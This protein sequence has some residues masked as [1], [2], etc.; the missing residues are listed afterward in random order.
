MK[1]KFK[2]LLLAIV[3]ITAASCSDYLDT[4]QY[5]AISTDQAITGYNDAVAALVGMYDGLQGASGRTTYYASRMVYYGDVR[6]DDMQA[7]DAGKRTSSCYEMR[8]SADDAPVIWATPYDANRRANNLIKALDEGKVTDATAEEIGDLRSQALVVRALVHFDLVRVYGNPYTADNG[9]SLGVPIV[10]E[11]LAPSAT[12]G[13][14]TVAEVYDQVI[15]DLTDAIASNDLSTSAELGTI[16]VWA[17]K[18]LLCRVYLY[19]GDNQNA[20]TLAKD[21]ITN[22]P[23]ELW[24]NAEYGSVWSKEGTS[25]VIFEIINTD[26]SDWGDREGIGYLMSEDGYSDMVVTTAFS[27]L[28][29]EDPADVRHSIV[30]ASHTDPMKNLYGTAKVWCN[31]FSGK[32]GSQIPIANIPILRLSEVYLNG[33]EAAFKLG[34]AN[35]QTAADYVKAIAQR[36]NPATTETFTTANI[37]L[38]RVLK[39]RRKELVG[40]GHRFFD[41]MRNNQ[42]IT[43]YTDEANRGRHYILTVPESRRFDR[44]YFRAILPIP[45]TEVNANPVIKEQQNPGY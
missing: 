36:A 8:Y 27:N 14:N 45:V 18:A 2:I 41:A 20:L 12:P 33:A 40:E 22:S 26:T 13:R 1:N 32:T 21:I 15:K 6:G 10:T 31:K 11:P 4:K 7:Q 38:D 35:L 9:A 42:T 3:A 44:T 23:Y 39:E 43:R 29:D 16:N 19:K 17:A 37:S 5:T 34:G 28:L 30:L 25:E 24:T